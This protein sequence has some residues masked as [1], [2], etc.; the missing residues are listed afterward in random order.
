M[1]S[2]LVLKTR[3]K[4]GGGAGDGAGEPGAARSPPDR[5][6]PLPSTRFDAFGAFD[7]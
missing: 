7:S 5:Q 3:N 1:T 2:T 6:S 4:E